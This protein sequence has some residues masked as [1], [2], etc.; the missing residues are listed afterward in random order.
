MWQSAIDGYTPLRLRRWLCNKHK[1]ANTGARCFPY[2]H[3]HDTLGL[4]QLR[5]L[6]HSLPSV[7]LNGH[8]TPLFAT[9]SK[10]SAEICVVTQLNATFTKRRR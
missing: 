2:E 8:S 1:I 5:S 3:H 9:P 4:V 6:V 7:T 10:F